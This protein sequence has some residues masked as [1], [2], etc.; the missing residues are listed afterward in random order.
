[1]A[2]LFRIGIKTAMVTSQSRFTTPGPGSYNLA[3]SFDKFE[4]ANNNNFLA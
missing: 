2:Y 1:M 3:T 4:G